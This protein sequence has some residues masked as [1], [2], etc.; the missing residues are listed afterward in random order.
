MA[1]DKEE[2][3]VTPQSLSDT[4]NE[5]ENE[6]ANVK[7]GR[8]IQGFRWALICVAVYSSNFLYGLDNTIVAAIQGAVVSSFG[9]VNQ[10]GWLGVGFPLGSIAV[11]LPM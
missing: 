8:S 1:A 6:V 9:H 10:L 3:M 5:V 11:I 2:Q 7:S 4:N